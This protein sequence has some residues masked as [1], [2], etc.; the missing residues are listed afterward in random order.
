[1]G[2][3]AQYR[4]RGRAGGEVSAFPLPAP[5]YDSDWVASGVLSEGLEILNVELLVACP[6][7]A[8][9]A[10]SQYSTDGETWL[11]GSNCSCGDVTEIVAS[12]EAVDYYV[13]IRWQTDGITPISDWSVPH[14][15]PAV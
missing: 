5:V 3:W 6:V 10:W 7:P 11:D 15:V 2:R 9:G 1:M 8:D 13:R 4:T 14:L 12:L